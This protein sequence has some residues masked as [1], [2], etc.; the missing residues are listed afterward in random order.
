MIYYGSYYFKDKT[1]KIELLIRRMLKIDIWIFVRY[2]GV[3]GK[4]IAQTRYSNK[5]LLSKLMI[6]LFSSMNKFFLVGIYRA[7][8]LVLIYKDSI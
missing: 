8:L 4:Q 7:Q 3:V 6:W 2:L 1:E 5:L